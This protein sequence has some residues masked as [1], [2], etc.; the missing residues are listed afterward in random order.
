[1]AGWSLQPEARPTPPAILVPGVV[2][3]PP[4]LAAMEKQSRDL[5]WQ[6][7]KRELGDALSEA[8]RT[9]VAHHG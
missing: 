3:T 8:E 1:M 6:I 5:S 4:D 9:E 7:V 2:P